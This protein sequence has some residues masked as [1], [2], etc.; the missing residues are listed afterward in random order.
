MHHAYLFDL[1]FNS[2]L[3]TK[4]L[5][6]EYVKHLNVDASIITNHVSFKKQF[7]LGC[8]NMIFVNQCV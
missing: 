3:G 4:T 5:K 8:K 2:N 6:A 7:I 1:H